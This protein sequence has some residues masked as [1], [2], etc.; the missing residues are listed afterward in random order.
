MIDPRVAAFTLLI[1]S[2][3]AL[4]LGL[5]PALHVRPGNLHEAV[6]QSGS[7]T[8]DSR[9]GKRF[10]SALVVAEV[11]FA[12]LLLVGAGLLIRSLKELAAIHPGYDPSHLLT[13]RVSLPP[14]SPD[15]RAGVTAD[16]ILRQ[17]AH[18]ASVESATLGSDSPLSGGGATYYT[19]EGQPPV[20][21]TNMP[22]AY[23]HRV[24]PEFFH[25]ARIPLVAGR[26]F[27]P[28]E[29][30]PDRNV[31]IVSQNL[32]KRFWAGQDP[33]GKRIKFGGRV[34]KALLYGVKPVDPTTLGFSVFVLAAVALVACFLP[35]ARASRIDPLNAL[36]NE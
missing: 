27:T 5:A 23:L 12:L 22:R 32:V 29:I 9:K 11:G 34:L 19:A 6:K 7:R 33:I 36:R 31:A 35:A 20:N 14:L 21:A 1:S 16:D 25:T 28:E 15:A 26:T 2:A 30:K 18:V 24:T 13:L 10:R 3:A 17:A 8:V 4:L